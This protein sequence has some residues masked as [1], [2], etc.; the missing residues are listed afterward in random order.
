MTRTIRLACFLAVLA[1]A[2]S[3]VVKAA[4]AQTVACDIN[5]NGNGQ[6]CT[7]ANTPVAFSI[8]NVVQLTVAQG[9]VFNLLPAGGLLSA[10]DYENGFF[11]AD[12][13]IQLEVRSNTAWTAKIASAANFTGGCPQAKSA[14]VLR[15]GTAAATRT[16]SVTSTAAN[17]KTGSA[18]ASETINLYFRVLVGWTSD[19]PVALAS[20]C[21]LPVT[22]SVT[23]P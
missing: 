5:S 12:G 16:S 4:Q 3:T 1:L 8:G 21:R 20:N 17:I 19:S 15:W 13:Q 22:F 10:T 2:S 23:T 6:T 18:T 9:T 11:D 14:S 7:T